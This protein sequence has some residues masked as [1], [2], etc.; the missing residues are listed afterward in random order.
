MDTNEPIPVSSAEKDEGSQVEQENTPE[1]PLDLE[2]IKDALETLKEMTA[3]ARLVEGGLYKV[4]T[5]LVPKWKAEDSSLSLSHEAILRWMDKADNFAL[6]AERCLEHV[7]DNSESYA[8]LWEMVQR[9]TAKVQE[10][11]ERIAHLKDRFGSRMPE[12]AAA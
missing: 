5:F 7:E 2:K 8:N 1:L 9:L 4:A 3:K 12:G 11:Y 6:L 10:Q